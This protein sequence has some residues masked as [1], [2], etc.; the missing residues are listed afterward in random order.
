MQECPSGMSK[1]ACFESDLTSVVNVLSSLDSSIQSQSI[2]DCFRLGKFSSGASRPRPILIKF[3]RVADVASILAK[4][5]IYP[6]PTQSNRTYLLTNVCNES[7]L[8]RERWSLI[9]T[10]TS[11][12]HMRIRG[13]STYVHGKLHG[14]V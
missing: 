11:R 7:V 9:Q 8:L 12:N 1:P 3:V 4:R 13:L 2:K 14:R 10:G 6:T 5:K